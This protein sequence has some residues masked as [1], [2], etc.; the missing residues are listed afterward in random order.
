MGLTDD[1]KKE[2]EAAI[3]I[4]RADKVHDYIRRSSKPAEP[5]PAPTPPTPAPTPTP[6]PSVPA[7]PPKPTD[8][9]VPPAPAPERK[10]SAWWGE[11]LDD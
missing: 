1:A 5:T 7:P 9:S 8:P 4:V 2:I 3:A 6:D 11:L 10:V